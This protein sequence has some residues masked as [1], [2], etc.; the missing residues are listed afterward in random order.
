MKWAIKA[1]RFQFHA[2]GQIFCPEQ[3]QPDLSLIKI[4]TIPLDA[5]QDRPFSDAGWLWFL[6]TKSWALPGGPKMEWNHQTGLH[7][8]IWG[9]TL[10]TQQL[11]SNKK[12]LQS[13]PECPPLLGQRQNAVGQIIQS[14]GQ[15]NS[16]GLHCG[17][18][19]APCSKKRYKDK[20][21]CLS[22]VFFYPCCLLFYHPI[23]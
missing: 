14:L 3:I 1:S 4:E 6:R 21:S 5:A 17:I 18:L 12:P 2:K 13:T 23:V 10:M 19:P 16:L 8:G 15:T 9:S 7:L 11:E 20:I 22:A